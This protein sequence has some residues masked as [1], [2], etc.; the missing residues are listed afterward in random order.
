MSVYS[1]VFVMLWERGYFRNFPALQD[2]NESCVDNLNSVRCDAIDI[3][4]MKRRNI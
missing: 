2:P 1:T 4:G 3:S